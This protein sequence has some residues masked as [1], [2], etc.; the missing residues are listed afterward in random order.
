MTTPPIPGQKTAHGLLAH[1]GRYGPPER[2]AE[3]RA[4]FLAAQLKRRILAA[5]AETETPLTAEHRAEL[6][7]LLRGGGDR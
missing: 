4:T 7:D 2:I 1:A 5:L 3:A 6:A